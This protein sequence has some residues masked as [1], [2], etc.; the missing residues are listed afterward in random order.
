VHFRRSRANRGIAP[1]LPVG[2][3]MSD[4]EYTEWSDD[5][6]WAPTRYPGL[7]IE[8]DLASADWLETLLVPRSF[9]VRMTAPQGYEA[10]A[11]IFFPFVRTGLDAAGEWSEQHIRWT[12]M[13]R[14]NRK[15]VHALMERET[16]SRSPAGLDGHDRC[17]WN[18]APEQLAALMPVLARHTNSTSGSFLLWEGFGDLNREVFN[19][20]IPK[21]SH[22]MRNFYLLKGPLDSYAH[23]SNDPSY[24]WPDDQAWCMCTDTDFEWSYLAGSRGCVDEVLG[25]P[26]MDAVETNPQNPARSGID[27]VNDPDGRVPR[28]L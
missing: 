4:E 18:L 5:H 28:S 10:Y 23:F 17:A 21:V 8:S 26:V 27:V 15:Q 24:W 2:T 7:A 22:V 13:A 14:E 25:L 16:I 12:D 6:S 11:R 20:G 19:A 3:T 1:F 9:E